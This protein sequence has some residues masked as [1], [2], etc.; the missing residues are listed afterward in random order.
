M[1]GNA[2]LL[3]LG[4]DEAGRGPVIGPMV[5]CALMGNPAE[6]SAI[7]AKDS[8]KLTPSKRELLF[9]RISAASR[10]EIHVVSPHEIDEAV[11]TSSLNRL[12]LQH[13]AQ[14]LGLFDI[15]NAFVDSPDVNER[16]FSEELSGLCGKVVVAEHRADERYPSVSA[17]SIV[18]KVTRDRII[19][20]M[21]SELGHDFGS[22]YPSDR[23]TVEYIENHVKRH[24]VLPPFCRQSWETSKRILANSKIKSFEYFR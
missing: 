19:E 3:Q 7:G 6:L 18:A 17:A 11:A 23:K 15:G 9:S 5:M 21:K 13:F 2:D 12:E 10:W 4:A 1:P 20:D 16:R 24:G 22:G 8:K 14:L